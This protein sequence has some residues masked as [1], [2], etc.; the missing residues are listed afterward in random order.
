MNEPPENIRKIFKKLGVEELEK[1]SVLYGVVLEEKLSSFTFN[2]RGIDSNT[3]DVTFDKESF[4]F[5]RD[6]MK[7]LKKVIVNIVGH[8]MKLGDNLDPERCS[9]S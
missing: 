4:I 8:D 1:S 3:K 2:I 6:G 7:R 9:S 5:E